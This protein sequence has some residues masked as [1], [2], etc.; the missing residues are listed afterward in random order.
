MGRLDIKRF[1]YYVTIFI[2]GTALNTYASRQSCIQTL[3][4]ESHTPAPKKQFSLGGMITR[5]I[6]KIR[7]RIETKGLTEIARRGTDSTLF[8]FNHPAF[9]D[10]VIV[11]STVNQ[12]M[13]VRPLMDV[14][15]TKGPIGPLV[16][17]LAKQVRTILLP[18]PGQGI[19]SE[20][21]IKRTLDDIVDALI[22]KDNILLYPAGQLARGP[23][24]DLSSKQAASYIIESYK[25]RTGK[26]LRVVY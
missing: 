19:R 26:D 18:E 9:I 23:L 10:P 1:G 16:G 8:L 11:T 17:G 21:N 25:A 2:L 24:D 7:Y 14:A 22:N 5:G 4:G 13:N 20:V 3:N 6:L 15:Q 12:Y